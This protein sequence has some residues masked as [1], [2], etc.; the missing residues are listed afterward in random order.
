MGFDDLIKLDINYRA[1]GIASILLFCLNF[2]QGQQLP[3]TPVGAFSAFSED[4]LSGESIELNKNGTFYY[5]SGTDMVTRFSRG[6]WTK[7]GDTIRFESANRFNKLNYTIRYATYDATKNSKIAPITD[8][9]GQVLKS[10][11]LG[12]NFD[13]L[14]S[15]LPVFGDDCEKIPDTIYAIRLQID[16]TYMSNWRRVRTPAAG[17]TMMIQLND[18]LDP[19]DFVDISDY[20][21][22][23]KGKGLLVIKR[24]RGAAGPLIEYTNLLSKR[25]WEKRYK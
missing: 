3:I 14:H 8:N 5:R 17:E 10:A 20:K 16:Q 25:R 24:Y 19:P 4:R 1:I 22:V 12:F 21:A 23:Q 7:R 9:G 15:Y 13:S 11:S 18:P 2:C 6:R